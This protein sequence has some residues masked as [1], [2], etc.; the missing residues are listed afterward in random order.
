MDEKDNSIVVFKFCPL[1]VT[2]EIMSKKERRHTFWMKTRTLQK[3]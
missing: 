1:E 3:W 2:I